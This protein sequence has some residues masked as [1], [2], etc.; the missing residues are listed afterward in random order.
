MLSPHQSSKRKLSLNSIR[1]LSKQFHA[2]SLVDLVFMEYLVAQNADIWIPVFPLE[3]IASVTLSRHLTCVSKVSSKTL[4]C[5]CPGTCERTEY[6]THHCFLT[7][8][9]NLAMM[10]DSEGISGSWVGAQD[11]T[12]ES[13][14]W[15]VWKS[16][17]KC[18]G[19]LDEGSC[20]Q[21]GFPLTS[22][23][24]SVFLGPAGWWQKS[25]IHL[26]VAGCV[27][28]CVV[29]LLNSRKGVEK[30]QDERQPSW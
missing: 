3:S 29:G 19:Q 13:L 6:W 18:C 9:Q 30:D 20:S 2:I 1:F 17:C 28:I 12:W 25:H 21:E 8:A 11:L 16:W 7:Q 23:G 26:A 15:R 4:S 27:W 24:G 14:L 22:L 10:D 5:L